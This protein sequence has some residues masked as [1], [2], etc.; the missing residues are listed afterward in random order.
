MDTAIDRIR[1]EVKVLSKNPFLL[2]L[3]QTLHFPMP[4]Q[5]N[6]FNVFNLQKEKQKGDAMCELKTAHDWQAEKEVSPTRCFP[7]KIHFE[8][9]LHV[10]GKG[11]GPG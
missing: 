7:I 6:P 3:T 8:N 10:S 5:A 2:F 1:R 11:G 9:I 4:P